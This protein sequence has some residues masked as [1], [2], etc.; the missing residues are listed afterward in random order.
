MKDNSILI[1][2]GAGIN[3][4]E[5]IREANKLGLISVAID[6]SE[7]PP[8]KAESSFYYQVAGNDYE[9]TKAIAM[10]HAVS[11]IVTGQMEK[12]MRLMAR[13]AEEMGYIYHSAVVVERSLNKDLMKKAF[14]QHDVSCAKGKLFQAKESITEESLKTFQ[15]PLIIKP[16][17]AFSSRGGV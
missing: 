7:N 15:Y 10:K 11:G 1:F 8:G 3:Q 14:V 5:L 17:D 16:I 12:P 13:L 2:G 4:L 9:A 6:P